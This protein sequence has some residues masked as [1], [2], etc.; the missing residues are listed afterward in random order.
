M[1]VL[2]LDTETTGLDPLT[3]E[4]VTLQIMN[5]KGESRTIKDPVTLK[6][7]KPA[8]ERNFVAGHNIKFDSKFLKYHYG[9]T[10]YNVYDTYL[11]EIALSGGK[12]ARRKGAGS[13]AKNLSILQNQ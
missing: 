12:L 6:T 2:Y 11:A 1:S 3:C 7:V 5:S 9:I 10:L 8:L 13:V 4:L